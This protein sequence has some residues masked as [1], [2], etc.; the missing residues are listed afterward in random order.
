MT[1]LFYEE[2]F[3]NKSFWIGYVVVFIAAQAMN[4]VIH[5]VLLGAT[6]QSLGSVFRPEAEMTEMMWI[7]FAGGAVSLFVFCYIFTKGYENRGIGEGIRYGLLIG[8]LLAVPYALDQ[9]VV[10]PISA[11][12][13]AMWLISGLFTFAVLG[14]IFSAVYKPTV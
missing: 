9:Y 3:V 11:F 7:M 6:Y 5:E 2:N 12:V 8:L 13:A 4:F 10:Y 14:A 1:N